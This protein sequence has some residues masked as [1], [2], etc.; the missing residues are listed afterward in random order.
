[1]G[2]VLIILLF[3]TLGTDDVSNSLRHRVHPGIMAVAINTGENMGD[4]VSVATIGSNDEIARTLVEEELAAANIRVYI[5]GSV[6]YSVAV[7]QRDAKKAREML[8][9]STRLK[10]RDWQLIED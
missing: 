7:N 2:V 1:L 5:E 6:I 9:D 8:R 4:L 3:T 10:E